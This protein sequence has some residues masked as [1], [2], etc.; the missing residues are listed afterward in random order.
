MASE[1]YRES[2]N[3]NSEEGLPKTLENICKGKNVRIKEG[4]SSFAFCSNTFT[5]GIGEENIAE[6]TAIANFTEEKL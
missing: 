3:I 5:R 6:I 2:Y 1:S 4:K